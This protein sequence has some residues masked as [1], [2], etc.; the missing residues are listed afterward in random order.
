MSFRTSSFT[1]AGMNYT[2]TAGRDCYHQIIE[3]KLNLRSFK[4]SAHPGARIFT[5][6]G[7]GY[8]AVSATYSSSLDL[9][10][11]SQRELLKFCKMYA[12]SSF[13]ATSL[14]IKRLTVIAQNL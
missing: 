6:K 4:N 12:S 2:Q 3:I 7:V 5:R 10:T 1:W 8:T 13:V 9:A 11:W 14:S